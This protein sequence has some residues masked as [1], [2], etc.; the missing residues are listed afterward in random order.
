MKLVDAY[1]RDISS[2]LQIIVE[3][4]DSDPSHIRWRMKRLGWTIRTIGYVDEEDWGRSFSDSDGD[5][6]RTRIGD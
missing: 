3:V 2:Q 1:F 6:S 5:D 4:Y